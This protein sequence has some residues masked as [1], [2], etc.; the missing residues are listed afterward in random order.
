MEKDIDRITKNADT[1]IVIRIDDFGGKRGVTIREFVRGERYTGFTKSGTRIPAEQFKLF[2]QA[3]NSIEEKELMEGINSG[4]LS[5]A[6]ISGK[7]NMAEDVDSE[8]KKVEDSDVIE[9][10]K[11]DSGNNVVDVGEE[12]I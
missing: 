7:K 2:K 10:T 11:E 9:G 5:N 6:D 12:A 4:N 8:R 3:I 1:D